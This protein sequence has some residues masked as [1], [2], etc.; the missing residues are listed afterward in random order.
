MTFS[1][2][3]LRK[4]ELAHLERAMVEF[5][6]ADSIDEVDWATGDYETHARRLLA[7]KRGLNKEDA[8]QYAHNDP[9]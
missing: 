6:E 9:A 1:D 3:L 2:E 5:F 8:Y 7:M 4:Y